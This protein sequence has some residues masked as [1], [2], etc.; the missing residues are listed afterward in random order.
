MQ[1]ISRDDPAKNMAGEHTFRMT[2]DVN[3]TPDDHH[4]DVPMTQVCTDC[5]GP[6]D[7]FDI[8]RQDYN[9]DGILEGIQTEVHHMLEALAMKLPPY[10]EPTVLRSSSYEYT[11]AEK[12]ALFNYMAVEEDG[13]FGLHNPRYITGIL[14]ASIEDLSDPFNDLLEG[15]NVPVGGKWFYS[16]WFDFYAPIQNTE[17]VYHVDHGYIALQKAD[18]VI[19]LYI[20]RLDKWFYTTPD[21]YPIMYD[22]DSGT[23]LQFAGLI[24]ESNYYFFDYNTGGWVQM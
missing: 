15:V 19:H 11:D 17:W 10:G 6:I 5:H 16:P 14:K 1:G 24:G 21:I 20:D 7:S 4:D 8:P 3:N 9:Y 13:S 22:L 23:W 12:K 2:W 18:D